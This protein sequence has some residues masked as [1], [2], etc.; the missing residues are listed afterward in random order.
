MQLKQDKV[1]KSLNF[2][3]EVVKWDPVPKKTVALPTLVDK[4]NQIRIA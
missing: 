3:R 1:N 2:I 4:S